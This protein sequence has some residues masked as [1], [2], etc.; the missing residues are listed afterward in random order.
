MTQFQEGQDVEVYSSCELLDERYWRKAKI[1]AR[2]YNGVVAE[3]EVQF[4]DGTRAISDAIRA[5][6]QKEWESD[7]QKLRDAGALS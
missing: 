6:L 3:Y 7:L 2:Y 4:P 1:V 5:D